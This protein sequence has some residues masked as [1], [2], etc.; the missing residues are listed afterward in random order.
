MTRWQELATSEVAPRR[1][2]GRTPALLIQIVAALAIAVWLGTRRG[3]DLWI[4]GVVFVVVTLVRLL[5]P[6][7]DGV[8][9]RFL[10]RFGHVVGRA[11]TLVLLPI[12]FALVFVP[13]WAISRVTG[14]DMLEPVRGWRGQWQDPPRWWHARPPRPFLA[15]PRRPP[16]SRL[17]SVA[18]VGIIALLGAGLFYEIRVRDDP[19]VAHRVDAD[20]VAADAGFFTG[21]Y[22]LAAY[23]GEPWARQYFLDLGSIPLHFDPYLILRNPDNYS[24]TYVNVT[25]RVRRSYQQ[26]DLGESDAIDVW[27]L[28]G[29]AAF[30]IGQRDEHTIASELVRLAEADELPVRI[31]NMAGSGYVTWQDNLL[32]ATSLVE[33]DPPD[34]V[35]DY[36]GNNDLALYMFGGGARRISSLFADQVYRVLE[37]ASDRVFRP[38]LGDYMPRNEG[39]DIDNAARLYGQEVEFG[40]RVAA[41]WDIPITYFFQSALWTTEQEESIEP[42]LAAKGVSREV[43]DDNAR[44]WDRLRDKLPDGVIDLADALDDA[45]VPVYADTVHTNEEGARLV[46]QA[47]YEHLRPQFEALADDR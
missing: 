35:V 28:G 4:V 26:A 40:R 20:V 39:T 32:M 33:R 12:T 24:S 7:F 42:V 41:A 36:N 15:E 21:Y 16:W 43:F 44:A 22:S 38:D 29:S 13:V 14:W 25:D 31:E 45:D 5:V 1:R 17:H 2:L 23:E 19:T 30:G 8:F 47:M 34:L 27:F 3:S 37:P 10:A 11:L 6:A 18:V 46:A 9:G